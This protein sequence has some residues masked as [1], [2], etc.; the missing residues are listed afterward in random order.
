MVALL[1]ELGGLEQDRLGDGQPE[2]LAGLQIDDP[3]ES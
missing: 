2:G 1:D 3:R